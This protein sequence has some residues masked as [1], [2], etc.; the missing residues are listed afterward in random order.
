VQIDD[1][2]KRDVDA[3]DFISD[4]LDDLAREPAEPWPN[5]FNEGIAAGIAFVTFAFDIDGVSMEIA[6]YGHCLEQIFPGAK[7]HC[8]AGTF[9][10]KADV[11]L[12][13]SW[14]R[15]KLDGA[16]GWDK[17]DGGKWFAKLFYEDLPPNSEKSSALA[18]EIW[19][20]AVVL[21]DKLAAY[22]TEHDI[23]LL[24]PVNTNSNPGNVAFALAIV[25][26]TEITGCAVI[27]NNHDFYWEGGKEGC[28]RGFGEEPGPRDHFF[29]NHDN[30]EFFSVFQRIYPWN[31]R[32]WQQANINPLQTRRLID[33]LHF[34]PHTVFT[35][36]TG[37][38]PAFFNPCS[39]EQKLAKRTQMA[40]VLGGSPAIE[41]VRVADFRA[42]LDAWIADQHPVVCGARGGRFLDIS[43]PNAL[44]LLQP[45]RIVDRKRIWR[46]WELIGALLEYPPF[47]AEFERRHDLTLTVHVTGPAPVEHQPCLERVLDAYEAVLDKVPAGIGRR[48][49]QAFSVGNQSYPGSSDVLSIVDIYQLAD[50]VLF[51][52]L[53]EGRG[54]PIPESAAAGVP[55]V[56]SEYDPPAVFAAVVGL[57]LPSEQQIRYIDFPEDSFSDEM[58]AQVMKVLLNPKRSSEMVA[59]NRAAVLERYTLEALQVSF[60]EILDKLRTTVGGT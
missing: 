24:V 28:K 25:L 46:D 10:D 2:K 9:A 44:Y 23:G 36:G 55:I 56:A 60:E 53:T 14:P 16:D 3:G 13:P 57:D 19:S 1:L 20:Q 29:R 18:K 48:L 40:H 41:P 38:D 8:I 42:S 43:D 35:I 26:A 30:E 50:L 6:K 59:H 32:R 12:D 11:V 39:A 27:N 45:T 58:L 31:G 34:A 52:S 15:H 54:L 51:P 5:D 37:L 7:V 4:V 49:F 22:I 47:R 33:R 17:W 21:A